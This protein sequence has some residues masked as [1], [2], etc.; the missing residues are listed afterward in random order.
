MS[1]PELLKLVV[2]TLDRLGIEYMVTGSIA[3]NFYGLM[4]TTH[5]IDMVVLLKPSFV[6]SLLGSF[7]LPEYYLSEQ[8][9]KDAIKH[10]AMFNLLRTEDG[11]K[12]AIWMMRDS[13]FDRSC[14]VR[15]QFVDFEGISVAICTPEDT[16]LGKLR[17]SKECGGSVRQVEDCV[18]LFRR[19][20]SRLD[21]NYMN[22]GPKN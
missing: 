13:A 10:R 14:F 20:K 8:S 2:Q 9:I 6:S 5:D 1:Q 19:Q 22:S 3:A 4:R 12:V 11:G 17:W 21:M 15:R 16:I 18:H 7:P